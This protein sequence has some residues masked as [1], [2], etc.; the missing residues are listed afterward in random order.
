MTCVG[1]ETGCKNGKTWCEDPACHPNCK[2]CEMAP[3]HDFAA[4]VTF[5]SIMIMFVLIFFISWFMYGPGI[6]HAHYD[7][8]MA[9][10]VHP[11][12]V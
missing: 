8:E 7:H 5:I 4:N 12:H 11:S 1:N 9:G 3:E 6:F 10:V 2:D